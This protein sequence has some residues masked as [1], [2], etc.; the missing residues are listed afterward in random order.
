MLHKLERP[1]FINICQR[2]FSSLYF[3]IIWFMS[4]LEVMNTLCYFLKT[5]AAAACR[6]PKANGPHESNATLLF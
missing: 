3:L 2:V 5:A 1:V 6:P 4:Q